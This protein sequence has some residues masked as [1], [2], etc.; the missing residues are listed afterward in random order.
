VN[1]VI[2]VYNTSTVVA[3]DFKV[4][5]QFFDA[6]NGGLAL[7][8]SANWKLSTDGKIAEYKELIDIPAKGQ[9]NLNIS[10]TITNNANGKVRNLA[11]VC[12][13]T[14]EDCDP[15]PPPVCDDETEIGTPEGCVEVEVNNSCDT[16]TATPTSARNS[17]TTTLSCA[18]TNVSTY[19]ILVKNAAGTVVNTINSANGTV[20]LNTV[21]TYTASCLI[22]GQ[23][24]TVPKCEQTLSVTNG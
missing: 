15:T 22:N 23:T 18:G 24:T 16:F 2:K 7:V 11:V 5:D 6:S 21:G 3:K 10:F 14:K 19:K 12:E 8:P 9:V 13:G 4:E 20:T 17:L 1:Y